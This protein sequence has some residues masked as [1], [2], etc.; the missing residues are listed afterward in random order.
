MAKRIKKSEETKGKK[1]KKKLNYS[2]I[3]YAFNI[4]SLM[5]AIGVCFYFGGRSF[6]YYIKQSQK[7]AGDALT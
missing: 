4:L 2:K 3:E 7:L 6:Y 1:T 5:L